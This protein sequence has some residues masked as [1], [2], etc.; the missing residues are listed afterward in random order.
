MGH[1][2]VDAARSVQGLVRAEADEA[3]RQRRLTPAVIEALRVAGLFRLCVPNVYCGPEADPMT[4]VSA[5]EAV[6][7]ADGATGWCMGIACTT[8]SLSMF[9]APD[10]AREIYGDPMVISG[11]AYAPSGKAVSVDGGMRVSGRWSWGSGTDH[12]DWVSGGVLADDGAFHL[13]FA[14]VADVVLHDTWF[15]M[16]LN[17]TAS[18]DFEMRDSFV[19]SSFS[20]QPGH[21]ARQV[22]SPLAAFPN[23]SLLACGIAA[24]TL[25]IARRAIDEL[26]ALA[27]VKRPAFSSRSLAQHAGAQADIAR[28]EAGV[29]SARAFL[30]DELAIAWSIAERGDPIPLAQRARIRL[31][32][33][34]A[35]RSSA[36]VVDLAFDLGGG[37]SVMS[38]SALIGLNPIDVIKAD[39]DDLAVILNGDAIG[40]S[41][42]FQRFNQR[43][44]PVRQSGCILMLHGSAHTVE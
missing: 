29:G 9:L 19:P 24:V 30:L 23:Y 3:E 7:I 28:A 15:S 13:V 1:A 6:S 8:S 32:C 10:A 12:C 35:A 17:A 20:F 37:S 16:G 43:V 40:P 22:D 21:V 5:V 39:K 4:L 33:T 25:G 18:G 2:V 34:H 44:E 27:S 36:D 11:G 41:R 31:A 38:T 26:V 42:L 14:P